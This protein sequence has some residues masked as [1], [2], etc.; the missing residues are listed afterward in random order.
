ME[1]IRSTP[2]ECFWSC[3][4]CDPINKVLKLVKQTAYK[5]SPARTKHNTKLLLLIYSN[6]INVVE[7]SW[8]ISNDVICNSHHEVSP[9]EHNSFKTAE[10][11]TLRMGKSSDEIMFHEKGE[12]KKQFWDAPTWSESRKISL[13]LGS[14]FVWDFGV[15]GDCGMGIFSDDWWKVLK[16]TNEFWR[17]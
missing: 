6:R 13:G 1:N 4:R 8:E 17:C 5:V 2:G 12:N 3:F 16:T 11:E 9:R 14:I 10:I 15:Q 7:T